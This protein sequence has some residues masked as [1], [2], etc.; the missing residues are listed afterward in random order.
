V[1][2]VRNVFGGLR[3]NVDKND[4]KMDRSSSTAILNVTT[5]NGVINCLRLLIENGK[6]GDTN[7][8]IKKFAKIKGFDFKKYKSS[9]YRQMGEDI[10]KLC[11][12]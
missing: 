4:W 3:A 8:Y 6:T 12:V 7:Y 2:E 9:Q 11:F 1:K 10:Y 5:I